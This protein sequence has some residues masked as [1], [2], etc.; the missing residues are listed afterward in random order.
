[1]V[2]LRTGKVDGKIRGVKT[3][4]ASKARPEGESSLITAARITDWCERHGHPHGKLGA[5]E[6][7]CGL[8]RYDD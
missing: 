8:V 1:M 7:L 5:C 4:G 2:Q 6:C 3:N